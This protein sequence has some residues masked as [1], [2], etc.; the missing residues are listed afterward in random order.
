MK[1]NKKIVIIAVIFAALLGVAYLGVFREFDAQSYTRAILN[2][3]FS[4]EMEEALE[5]IDDVTEE[6]LYQQ[7][8]DGVKSFVENN[9][10]AGVEMDSEMKDKYIACCKEIFASMKFEVQEA[11]KISSEEYQ[12]PVS[13][14]AADVFEKYIVLME[15]VTNALMEKTEKGEYKGNVDEINAQIQKEF[16]DG[17]YEALETAH[18]TMEYAEAETVVFHVTKDESGAFEMNA[19]E[20]TDFIEKIMK[21]DEIQD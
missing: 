9:L 11:E 4:G 20:I 15:D 18:D 12:V 21:L 13:Y 14:E 8:E 3:H 6:E 17:S 2:Q 1:I 16:L 10:I 19:D 5:M 7:Y